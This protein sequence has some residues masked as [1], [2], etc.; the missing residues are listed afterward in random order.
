MD[1]IIIFIAPKLQGMTERLDMPTR[2]N[3]HHTTL[4]YLSVDQVGEDIMIRA[5]VRK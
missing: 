1:E 5:E 3:N 4:H 2:R